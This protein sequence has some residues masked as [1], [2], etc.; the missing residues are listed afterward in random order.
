MVT[1]SQDNSGCGLGKV[2]EFYFQDGV[3]TLRPTKATLQLYI[4]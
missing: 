2:G 4:E 1:D 3:R